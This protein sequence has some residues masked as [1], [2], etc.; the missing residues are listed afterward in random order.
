MIELSNSVVICYQ[1]LYW[2]REPVDFSAIELVFFLA[3][4]LGVCV[5]SHKS[6]SFG[7]CIASQ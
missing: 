1:R 7:P 5:C 3:L 2:C 6:I 4:F